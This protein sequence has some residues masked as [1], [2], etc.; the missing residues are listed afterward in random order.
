MKASSLLHCAFRSPDP[1]RLGKFYAEIFECGF[2]IHPVLSGLGIVMLKLTNPEAVYRGLLEFWPAELHWNGNKARFERRPAEFAPVQNHIA[3]R[4]DQSREE[5]FTSLE[6]RVKSVR[7]EARGPGFQIVC[8]DDP[9]GNF[10]EIFPN[11]D[12]VPLPPEAYCSVDEL[13]EVMAE[14]SRYAEAESVREEASS[15]TVYPLVYHPLARSLAL[16]RKR[17]AKGNE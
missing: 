3:V 4:V 5:I 17:V 13:D 14:L 12:T 6:G 1:V 9:D 16:P 2:Y 7:Y 11:L 8:F 15:L 10:V